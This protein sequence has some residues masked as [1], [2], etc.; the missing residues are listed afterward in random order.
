MLCI[1]MLECVSV[2]KMKDILSF[3]E[4]WMKLED[5][6]KSEIS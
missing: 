3:A 4:I 2:F 6:G 5:I 1:H